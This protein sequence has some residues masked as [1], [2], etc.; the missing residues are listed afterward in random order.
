MAY[1]KNIKG[2]RFGRLVVLENVG[3]VKWGHYIWEC[4]CD[5]GNKKI[6]R[7]GDLRN[8]KTKSCGCLQKKAVIKQMTTHGFKHTRIYNIWCYMK[9]RCYNKNTKCYKNYGGRGI[10]ICND[11][12]DDFTNFKNDMYESYLRH[13]KEYG[14]KNT[15]LDRVNNDG[16]YSKEN[17]RWATRKEQCNNKRKYDKTKQY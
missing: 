4:K 12:K 2:Q 8:A 3:K 16:N 17:C 6:I 14:I 15:T 9:T 10:K 1:L 13:E 7:G 11:W 5:C